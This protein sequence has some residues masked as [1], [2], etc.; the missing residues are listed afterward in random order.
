MGDL[1]TASLIA[2]L[3]N[4]PARIAA[5]NS[6]NSQR[7]RL[8]YAEN[9][10]RGFFS[11]R[12]DAEDAIVSSWVTV[13]FSQLISASG[14]GEDG[15]NVTAGGLL[16][17][18]QGT[19]ESFIRSDLIGSFCRDESIPEGVNTL[20]IDLDGKTMVVFG[21][22][23]DNRESIAPLIA[24]GLHALIGHNVSPARSRTTGLVV[25]MD[26]FPTL[27][28]PSIV[29]YPAEARSMGF[30]LLAGF[31]NYSQIVQTYGENNA[32]TIIG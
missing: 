14:G 22:D 2:N 4:L 31:Q 18:A 11:D 5:I 27:N 21:L 32:K 1:L 30:C 9:E 6:P 10:G 20:P 12:V 23:Q 24:T 26:E 29:R 3:P 16:A 28:L 19:F 7:S 25:G 17:N 15:S 8:A 13:S